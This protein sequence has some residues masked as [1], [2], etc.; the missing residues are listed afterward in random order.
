[1]TFPIVNHSGQSGPGCNGNEE[2]IHTAQSA[3]TKALP[4]GAV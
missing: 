2:G 4:P 3:R 1:M